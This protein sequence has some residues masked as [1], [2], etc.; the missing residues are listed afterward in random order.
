MLTEIT[1]MSVEAQTLHGYLGGVKLVYGKV[2]FHAPLVRDVRL[3]VVGGFGWETHFGHVAVWKDI[4]DMSVE[5]Q[6]LHGY[7]GGVKL[8][9]EKVI[10]HAPLVRDVRLEVVGGFGWET[11]LGHVAVWKDITD[12]SVEA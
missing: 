4:T 5:A 6:T 11:H 10:L 9:Y 1:D 3:E 12:M 2:V 7:L 8:V